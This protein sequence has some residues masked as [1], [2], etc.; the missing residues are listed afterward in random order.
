M[1]EKQI[2]EMLKQAIRNSE[3]KKYHGQL[4]IIHEVPNSQEQFSKILSVMPTYKTY[5]DVKENVVDKNK[6]KE[7][8]YEIHQKESTEDNW[9]K[10]CI[11]RWSWIKEA[12]NYQKQLTSSDINQKAIDFMKNGIQKTE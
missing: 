4:E 10:M 5:F 9:K 8:K 1:D 2:G 12:I 3:R 7:I 6:R 11:E